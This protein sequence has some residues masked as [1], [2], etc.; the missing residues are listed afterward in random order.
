MTPKTETLAVDLKRMTIGFR[1]RRSEPPECAHTS[2]VRTETA[3]LSREFCAQ[4]GHV[5]VGYVTDHYLIDSSSRHRLGG[6]HPLT[7]PGRQPAPET[8][9]QD[10]QGHQPAD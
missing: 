4:C 9:G 3:G 7:P 5:S 1:M 2:T 10:H 8:Q 6:H